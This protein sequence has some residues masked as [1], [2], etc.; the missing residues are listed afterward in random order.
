MD[1]KN[2][3]S[4]TKPCQI[5]LLG[6]AGSGK[7]TFSVQLREKLD[8]SL[9]CFGELLKENVRKKTKAGLILVK[10]IKDGTFSSDYLASDILISK[11]FTLKTPNRWIIEGF[12]RTLLQVQLFEEKVK[13]IATKMKVIYLDLSNEIATKR[14]LSR[15]M[16]PK[17]FS[18]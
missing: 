5:I 15:F 1:C 3:L 7:G 16:C 18:V 17:C 13:D 10:H 4:K 14:L 11:F 8:I 2:E 6:K 9:L 12:P